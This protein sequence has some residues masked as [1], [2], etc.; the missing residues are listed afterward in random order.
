MQE[1]I[2][3]EEKIRADQCLLE[4]RLAPSKERA[5]AYILT[6][7]VF[8]KERKILKPGEKIPSNALLTLSS[9]DHP[10]VS[11]G[12]VKLEHALT[13]QLPSGSHTLYL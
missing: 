9:P 1:R 7:K 5:Q 13:A 2:K 4:L 10:Y 12:G 8:W 6:G 11:R 3:K